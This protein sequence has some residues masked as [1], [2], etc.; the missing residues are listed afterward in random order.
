MRPHIM[1][2][3]YR[4]R[5]TILAWDLRAD[6][7]A[8]FVRY[9]IPHKPTTNQKMSFDVDMSGQR[10][11]VGDQAGSIS[12]FDLTASAGDTEEIHP[13]LVFNA[14]KGTS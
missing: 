10:L 1:Y 11:V 6:I 5:D 7:N 4:R 12:V 9:T 3:A 8:P 2:A 13:D 14:H